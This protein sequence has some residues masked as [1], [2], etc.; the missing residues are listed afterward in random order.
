MQ[1]IDPLTA[2]TG[3]DNPLNATIPTLGSAPA[4]HRAAACSG[5]ATVLAA[6][7]LAAGV[8]THSDAAVLLGGVFLLVGAVVTALF[9][10]TARALTGLTVPVDGV[11]GP[12][13]DA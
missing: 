2:G 8:A 7:L 9:E 11:D 4:L 13:G 6:V 12:D 1:H 10:Y 5:V 3:P